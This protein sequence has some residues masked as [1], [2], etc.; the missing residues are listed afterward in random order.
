MRYAETADEGPHCTALLK[1]EV[2]S[3]H[4]CELSNFS[5]ACDLE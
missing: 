2:A 1:H 5:V 4:S 3:A